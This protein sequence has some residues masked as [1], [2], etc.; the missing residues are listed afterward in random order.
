MSVFGETIRND[1]R[2]NIDICFV[3]FEDSQNSEI[4]ISLD[5]MSPLKLMTQMTELCKTSTL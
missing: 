4:R 2:Y 1:I 3:K 5:R